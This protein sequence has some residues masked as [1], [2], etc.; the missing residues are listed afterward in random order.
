MIGVSNRTCS[1]LTFVIM[2][3]IGDWVSFKSKV[4]F[5]KIV[6]RGQRCI[7]RRGVYF[8]DG[9]IMLILLLVDCWIFDL[10]FGQ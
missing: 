10:L 1:S 7:L 6:F 5:H 3:V 4:S 9:S 2:K 8:G